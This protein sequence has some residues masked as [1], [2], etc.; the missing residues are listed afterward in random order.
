MTATKRSAT[1]GGGTLEITT[2]F[3]PIPPWLPALVRP[4]IEIDGERH[5][6]YWGTHSFAVAPGKHTVKAWHRWF[7]FRRCHLSTTRVDVP[8]GGVVRLRWATPIAVMAPGRW[9]RR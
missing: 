5:K 8:D 7:F 1:D 9:T 2:S 4:V 3:P 6:R